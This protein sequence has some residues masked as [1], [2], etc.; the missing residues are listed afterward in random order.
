MRKK[1]VLIIGMACVGLLA[2]AGIAGVVVIRSIDLEKIKT[3][4]ADQVQAATGRSLAINGPVDIELG[5]VPRLVVNEVS[6][7][8]PPK[9]SRPEMVR[10]KRF[11]MEV[12]LKPLLNRQ[13]QVN[14]LV[15]GA[16]DI[17]I[18]T[19]RKGLGNLDF[20]APGS[21]KKLPEPA[22]AP[23][24][25]SSGFT[26]AFNEVQVENATITWL[27]R[28]S[29]KSEAVA[30]KSLNLRPDKANASLLALNLVAT[31]RELPIELRGTMGGVEILLA[32][33]P[34]P[35]AMEAT[36][37]GIRLKAE[38]QIADIKAMQ[39]IDLRLSAQGGELAEVLR[40]AGV[41]SAEL[42]PLLGPFAVAGKLHQVGAKFSLG[43]VDVQL[44]MPELATLWANGEIKD[45]TGN[46]SPVLQIQAECANPAALAKLAGAEIPLKGPVSING[47]LSG[48]KAQWSMADLVAKA[49]S[50]EL[51]GGLQIALAERVRLGGQ[52]TSPSL[53]VT[54][55][56]PAAGK[57]APE[58]TKASQPAAG[59]KG[60]I[61][62]AE[63][64]PLAALRTMDVDL[65]AQVG[66]LT[67]PERQLSD[68]TIA[69]QLKN[70]QLNIA[71]LRFGLAGGVFEGGVQLDASAKTPTLAVQLHG[72]GFEL[73]QLQAGGPIAGGR[74]ELQVDVK[75]RGDSLRALMGAASG[76]TWISV[77]EG[78]LQNKAVNWAA[79]DFIFQVLGAINPLSKSEDHTAM[80][81]AAVRFVLRD[82]MATA[83]DGIALRTD[84]VDV[85]GSGTVNLRN[86]A[87]DLGIKPRARGG[88]GLS[89]STP[90]AGLVRV[91]GTLAKPSMGI[92]AVGTL[93]TAAS[94]G[95]GV[96]T[97]GLSTLSELLVDKVAA[98]SDPCRTALGKKK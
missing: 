59:D 21:A 81:C 95:A 51:K 39:G 26:L 2:L 20:T 29:K 34:W 56:L 13:L 53:D 83:E 38:G 80:S 47:K 82:G 31:A 25:E 78:K 52:L 7:S 86:E 43:A 92:D 22:A 64:L 45:L 88:V 70:G 50:N 28:D 46:L 36:V 24:K 41:Q 1:T 61:F 68:V 54:E 30:I 63:P 91:N 4:L 32:G 37:K 11:E 12:A 77:G 35:V 96:A 17:I 66:K 55:F 40:L 62:S 90:L 27:D 97:G 69:L 14:R 84:K 8:N 76:E 71:P 87:L 72:R 3:M 48:S 42:P 10:I 93:K 19:E 15:L 6:L 23:A 5:L 89:L 18:E 98:D 9:S 44:G 58:A 57:E 75:S 79:G 16:P 67:L 33:K 74:S 60:R 65:K 73:G 49:G 94:I 85:T